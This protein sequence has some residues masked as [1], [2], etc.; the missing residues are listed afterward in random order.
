MSER[1]S[2]RSFAGGPVFVL[3]LVLA[4]VCGSLVMASDAPAHRP[5]P[6]RPVDPVTGL[7][8]ADRARYPTLPRRPA[9][10][11]DREVDYPLPPLFDASPTDLAQ[12][13]RHTNH[14]VCVF[15]FVFAGGR[16]PSLLTTVPS[17][18]TSR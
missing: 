5:R 10:L 7:L 9:V 1:A 8:P 4:C 2:S 15:E 13:S 3:P 11:L 12:L 17:S 6:P 18:P 14:E 16:L